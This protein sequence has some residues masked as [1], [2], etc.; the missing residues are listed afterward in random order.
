[1]INNNNHLN[2][3]TT[4]FSNYQLFLPMDIGFNMKEL[5]YM[6]DYLIGLGD[7]VIIEYPQILKDGYLEKVNKILNYYKSSNIWKSETEI[8]KNRVKAWYNI[9]KKK[10]TEIPSKSHSD[11]KITVYI[12]D[13]TEVIK[14]SHNLYMK[15]SDQLWKEME[16]KS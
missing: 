4:F 1:M 2:N 3:Y 8:E 10:S 5:H 16:K 7:N 11:S 15:E 14:G 9:N 6:I 13:M 12:I